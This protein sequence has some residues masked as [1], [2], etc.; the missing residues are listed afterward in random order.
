MDRYLVPLKT[1]CVYYDPSFLPQN[2]ADDAFED[3][4]KNTPWEKTPK[5]NRWV[6]LME[7]PQNGNAEANYKYR[8][9]PGKALQGFPPVVMKLKSLAEQWY[10]SKT[11]L[12]KPVAFNICLLNYYPTSQH[13]LGWHSDREELGRNTPIASISLG[14]PRTFLVRSK[15]GKQCSNAPSRNV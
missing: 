5:I 1:P 2:E 11:Q 4:L 15:S 9:A 7:M 10:N 8:D 13:R 14:C 6:T 12:E 3:L